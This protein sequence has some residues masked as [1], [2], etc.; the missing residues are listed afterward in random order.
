MGVPKL[1]RRWSVGAGWIIFALRR[2]DGTSHAVRYKG[3]GSPRLEPRGC[4]ELPPPPTAWKALLLRTQALLGQANDTEIEATPL[5]SMDEVLQRLRVFNEERSWRQ[6]HSAKNLTMAL[7]GEVGELA[8]LLQWLEP[9]EIDG[10]LT[11]PEHLRA[12]RHELA[13]IFAYLLVLADVVNVDLVEALAEKLTINESRYPVDKARG[14][15]RKY[16]AL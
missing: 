12:V 1:R 3:K 6:F 2:A 5:T 7:T 11:Q 15:A 4:T 10:W 13:D 8:A 9:E 16:D 14:T